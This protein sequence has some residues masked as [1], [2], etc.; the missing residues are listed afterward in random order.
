MLDNIV[1]VVRRGAER[2]QRR[3]EEVAQVTRLRMEVFQLSRELDAHYARLGRAY[4]TGAHLTDLQSI[5]EDI[6]R[7]EEEKAQREHLI[8]TLG[9]E[10]SAGQHS[11]PASNA[12]TSSDK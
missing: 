8:S 6:R 12:E 7:T 2:V 9:E 3:G 11:S 10:L 1:N 5:R 4:H